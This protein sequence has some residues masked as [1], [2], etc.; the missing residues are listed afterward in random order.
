MLAHNNSPF[1]A[2]QV[3]N[4]ISQFSLSYIT[5]EIGYTIKA[6]ED[7]VT[8]NMLEPQEECVNGVDLNM[9]QTQGLKTSSIPYSIN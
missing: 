4:D 8:A 9:C 3:N 1:W 7:T 6:D 2:E 5:S